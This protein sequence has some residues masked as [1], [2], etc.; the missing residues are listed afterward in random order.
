MTF[1]ARILKRLDEIRDLPNDVLTAARLHFTDAVG[2]G[3]AATASPMGKPWR[4]YGRLISFGGPATVFG[5]AIGARA[6]DAALVNGG[7][8]H[9]LEYD[10]T[11][12][13]SIVHGS[14]VLAPAALALAQSVD[15]SGM[16]MLRAYALWYEVLIRFGLAAKGGF[17]ARGFQI[18]S[19]GG[20]IAASGVAADLRGF[21]KDTAS[22]AFGI[23]LSQSS[24]V[25][26]FLSNGS[27]V[28]SMHPGW[29][30]HAGLIAA[31]LAGAGITGPETALEGRFGLMNQFAG[32][33]EALPQLENLIESLGYD[34][35]LPDVAFKFFPACH[36]IHPFIEAAA[37][38]AETDVTAEQIS[39]LLFHVPPPAAPII[40]E[41]WIT[42]Q[43]AERHAARWSL[44]ICFA[45]RIVTGQLNLASFETSP[46][47]EAMAM[48]TRSR[49]QPMIPN[50]FPGRFEAR[51]VATLR[52]GEQ[53]EIY[54]DDV[55]GNTSRSASESD[56]IAKLENNA[57]C[58]GRPEAVARLRDALASIDGHTGPGNLGLALKEFC[59]E[60]HDV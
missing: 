47:P 27:S 59:P 4:E 50:H 45:I 30:A 1:Q 23:A 40:C 13:A 31:D 6:A 17:Q 19:V 39:D 15:A 2:V 54:I 25:F 24:G 12:T 53:R 34:W 21:D 33:P 56:V 10:D 22:A 18:T 32:M 8:V 51:V 20:A 35:H 46:P 48:A 36:Y 7:L 52:S 37:R 38:L 28:K 14:A 43:A 29:A 57:S 16:V 3:L 11:H 42:R 58:L 60:E 5:Q 44:P 9:S 26:E 55:Y 41:P 49:W